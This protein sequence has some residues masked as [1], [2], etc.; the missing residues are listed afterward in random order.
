MGGK[1][2]IFR[3]WIVVHQAKGVD[4]CLEMVSDRLCSYLSTTYAGE[5]DPSKSGLLLSFAYT[6]CYALETRRKT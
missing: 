1:E 5:L 3:L 2:V 6:V 4:A